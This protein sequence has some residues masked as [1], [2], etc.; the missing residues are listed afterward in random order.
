MKKK[1]QTQDTEAEAGRK[2]AG[3]HGVLFS[4]QTLRSN[5][6]RPLAESRNPW[7]KPAVSDNIHHPFVLDVFPI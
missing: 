3:S 4:S 1:N 5:N 6:R 2:R 7:K